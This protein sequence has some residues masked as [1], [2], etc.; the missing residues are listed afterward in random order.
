M[1]RHGGQ[2]FVGQVGMLS[3]YWWWLQ[4][5]LWEKQQVLHFSSPC[6]NDGWAARL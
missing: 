2:L 6:L 4:P 1:T 5:P 3:E